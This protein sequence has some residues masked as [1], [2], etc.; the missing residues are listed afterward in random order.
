VIKLG[1]GSHLLLISMLIE[2]ASSTITNLWFFLRQ[3]IFVPTSMAV[4]E[5]FSSLGMV[6]QILLRQT[7]LGSFLMVAVRSIIL[8]IFFPAATPS[9]MV[10][11]TLDSPTTSTKSFDYFALTYWCWYSCWYWLTTSMDACVHVALALQLK[12]K[13]WENLHWYL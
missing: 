5:D 4:F 2:M 12:L 9:T 1:F 3:R 6:L 10:I 7:D 8:A 11:H 13:L